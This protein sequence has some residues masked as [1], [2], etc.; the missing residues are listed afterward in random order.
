MK[1]WWGLSK[2][3]SLLNYCEMDMLCLKHCFMS[4]L[5]VRKRVLTKDRLQDMGI[6]IE[7]KVY[8]LCNGSSLEHN[9]HLFGIC[10]WNA[11]I[12]KDIQ[13]WLG[14]NLPKKGTKEMFLELRKKHWTQTKKKELILAAY[15][16][17]IYHTWI[18]R[19]EKIFKK[20]RLDETK[21]IQQVKQ[22]LKDQVTGE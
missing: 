1:I 21:T 10:S 13:Q 16:A 12:W 20:A 9:E 17:I 6:E 18:A 3:R 22:L 11:G 7:E 14:I 5:I 19:N 4:W 15:E 2:N 8:S